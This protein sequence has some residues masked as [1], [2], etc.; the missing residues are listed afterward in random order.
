MIVDSQWLMLSPLGPAEQSGG[1]EPLNSNISFWIL[2]PDA[3]TEVVDGHD[4]TAPT[5]E[6][7][8][9]P[10]DMGEVTR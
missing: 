7:L 9:L 6:L 8:Q 3:D 10:P 1:G 5:P 4:R 2:F